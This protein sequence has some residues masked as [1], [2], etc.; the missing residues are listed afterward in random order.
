MIPPRVKT[1]NSPGSNSYDTSYQYCTI[2][3]VDDSTKIAH[4]RTQL[5]TMIQVST[6][7][8]FGKASDPPAEGETWIISNMFG[9]WVFAV[10]INMAT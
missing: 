9:D 7:R 10:H 1:P 5:G 4:V 8:T 3:S 6:T 2:L